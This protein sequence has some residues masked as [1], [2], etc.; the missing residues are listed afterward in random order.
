M[1]SVQRERHMNAGSKG[2]HALPLADE[3]IKDSC[4]LEGAVMVVV[5]TASTPQEITQVAGAGFLDDA[6]SDL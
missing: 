3:T 6:D 4:A 5:A 1:V 2:T